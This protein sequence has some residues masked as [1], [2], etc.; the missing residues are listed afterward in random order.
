MNVAFKPAD[1]VEEYIELRDLKE[2]FKKNFEAKVAELYGDR[3]EEIEGQ[4]LNML[5]EMGVDSL[6]SKNGTAFKKI[7]TSVTIADGREF[8]RHVI[9]G[10]HW[11]L[12]DWRANKTA[13]NELVENEKPVPPGVNRNATYVVQ[14][15]RKS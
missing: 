3:M 5:N 11:D 6:V 12:I 4:M 7:A 13:I 10:E 15:R 8:R 2:K 14:F 9:S 1:L